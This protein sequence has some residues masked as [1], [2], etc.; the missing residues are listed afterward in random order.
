MTND[1]SVT[2]PAGEE[3]LPLQ[4]SP[5]L[6]RSGARET[7][8]ERHP[9]V[10]D[11]AKFPT[12]SIRNVYKIISQAV[13]HRE[14]GVAFIADYRFGKTYAIDALI[15]QFH[16]N[17][18][19]AV[20]SVV[21]K[22]HDRS[23]EV[24]FYTDLLSDCGHTGATIGRTA[25]ERRARLLRMWIADVQDTGSDCLLLFVDEAQSW[26]EEQW[27]FLRDLSNDLQRPPYEIRLITVS[28]AQPLFR[29][30]R[31][32]LLGAERMDL[33]ARFMLRVNQ[34]KG[35]GS[36]EDATALFEMYDDPNVSEH[37]ARSGISYSNFFRPKEYFEGWRLQNEAADC[38]SAFVAAA[39]KKGGQ[40]EVGMLWMASAV[41]NY[42]YL[43]WNMEHGGKIP[44]QNIWTMAVAESDYISSIA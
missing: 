3:R 22:H 35:I 13:V 41:R 5:F 8:F 18:K 10:L 11:R 43:H 34:F 39:G 21:A 14:S 16:S 29:A 40:P 31:E 7:A 44:D 32:S 9:I 2:G 36:I 27:T 30:I 33:V 19:V 1:L 6:L 12:L 38:W 37:P 15:K 26:H 20:C 17:F 24:S 25:V 42:L 28:F 23:S 4:E